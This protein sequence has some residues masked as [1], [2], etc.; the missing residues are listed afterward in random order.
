MPR[1]LNSSLDLQQIQIVKASGL[2]SVWIMTSSW[3]WALNA[4]SG[5]SWFEMKNTASKSF[6]AHFLKFWSVLILCGLWDHN[7][8]WPG[9]SPGSRIELRVFQT[10][11]W[12][13]P[14]DIKVKPKSHQ[15]NTAKAVLIWL[16]GTRLKSVSKINYFCSCYANTLH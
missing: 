7:P 4:V 11:N 8:M 5:H 1:A 3:N 12:I 13:T 10:A 9:C 6:N 16:A 2:Y 15:D 14:L